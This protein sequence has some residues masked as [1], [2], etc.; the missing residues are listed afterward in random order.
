MTQILSHTPTWVFGLFL[1]LL[2]FGLLQARDRKVNRY[3]AYLLPVGMFALSLSGV[4]SSFGLAPVPVALWAAGLAGATLAGWRWFRE[5]RVAFD[6]AG[7]AFLIPGSWMPLVVIMAIFFTKYVF[8]VMRALD[9]ELARA[10]WF[11]MVLSL[12]YGCFSGYFAA[13][14][15]GLLDCERR[16][17]NAAVAL[18]DST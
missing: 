13:R 5:P 3:A 4:Q 12:A 6:A 8:A 1:G 14:A 9:L 2:V 7:E 18:P 11:T 16:P 10:S 17:G 15:V